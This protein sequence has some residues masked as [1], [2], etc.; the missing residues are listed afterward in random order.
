MFD[1]KFIP[2]E[3]VTQNDLDEIIK[4]KSTAWPY[5]YEKQL[6]WINSNLNNLDIH[7][8]LYWDREPV[9]YL[10]LVNIELII[11]GSPKKAYGI[12]NV[13]AKLKNKGFG[14]ELITSVNRFLVNN[15]KIG[16]LFCKNLLVD[17]YIY[18][19]WLVIEKKKLTLMFDKEQ[20]E[21]MIFNLQNKYKNIEYLGKSF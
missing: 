6:E 14:K 10:N 19:N 16:L 21:T 4:V 2:H 3:E 12:G 8:L 5:C 17:F 15:N 20:I 11:D 9:G 18:N 13:C 7:V 1:L